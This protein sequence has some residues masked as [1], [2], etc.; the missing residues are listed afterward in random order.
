MDQRQSMQHTQHYQQDQLN[1]G[2]SEQDKQKQGSSTQNTQQFDNQ[3]TSSFDS[4]QS[5]LSS[6]HVILTSP[7]QP[8][9]VSHPSG[10]KDT[11]SVGMVSTTSSQEKNSVSMFNAPFSVPSAGIMSPSQIAENLLSMPLSELGGDQDSQYRKIFVGGLPHNL[12]DEE[13]KAYF[14]QFGQIEDSAILRDKRTGKPRGFGFV[15][16]S[17]I[18][19]LDIV[20]DNKERHVIQGK[21]VDCKRAVPAS[22][23]KDEVTEI[24]PQ[25][26]LVVPIL[27]VPLK[28]RIPDVYIEPKVLLDPKI[29]TLIQA[30]PLQIKAPIA[31]LPQVLDS[32]AKEIQFVAPQVKELPTAPETVIPPQFNLAALA[33]FLTGQTLP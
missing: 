4:K 9:D 22:K 23:M 33:Q 30:V 2:S 20:M 8:F 11:T 5:D 24:L 27:P 28:K 25:V 19:S 16:Y 1:N 6:R 17:R 14:I 21:W 31:L 18:D 3:S 12:S 32:K 15:T 26:P 13:F 7:K 29:Q 10:I